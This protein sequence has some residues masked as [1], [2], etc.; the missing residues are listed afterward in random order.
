[1]TPRPRFSLSRPS[2]VIGV[3]T[4][5]CALADVRRAGLD[6]ELAVVPLIYLTVRFAENRMDERH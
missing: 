4:V 1:V 3:A 6:A 5:L 2:F